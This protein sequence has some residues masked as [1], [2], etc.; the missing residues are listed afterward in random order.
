MHRLHRFTILAALLVTVVVAPARAQMAEFGDARVVMGHLHVTAPDAEE[1]RAFW[2]AF[3]GEVTAIGPIQLISFPGVN[4]AVTEAEPTGDTLGSVINHVGFNVPDA[5]A[6]EARWTAAGLEVEAGGFPA[7]RWLTAPGGTRIEI[8][9][10]AEVDAP[11]VMHHVHWNTAEIPEMQAWYAR[12]F[13]AVPGMRGR[14]VAADIPGANLTF[15]EPEGDAALAG[16]AGRALDHVGFEAPD[17]R[18]LIAHLESE[19]IA[20][21]EGYREVGGA[22]AIAYLTD[23]WGTRIELTDTLEP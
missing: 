2:L 19:G 15:T 3:G 5:A 23:P 8:L 14:F 11:V 7:Q 17:L 16:T 18:A 4:I 1:A 10:N 6:A 20:L 9:E 12:A 21:D 22:V 13:G